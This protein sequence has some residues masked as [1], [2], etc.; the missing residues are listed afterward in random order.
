MNPF[1]LQV[2][3]FLDLQLLPPIK[4]ALQGLVDESIAAHMVGENSL[5]IYIYV[6][7]IYI[8]I[9]YI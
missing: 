4:R 8:Y 7:Y 2:E 9:I 6:Q 1:I 3:N 5:R